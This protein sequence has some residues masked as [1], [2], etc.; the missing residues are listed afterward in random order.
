MSTTIFNVFNFYSQYKIEI[1]VVVYA[2][3][4]ERQLLSYLGNFPRLPYW[5]LT[6]DNIQ[7]FQSSTTCHGS[8]KGLT[9]A[10]NKLM[11]AK[12]LYVEPPILLGATKVIITTMD[13]DVRIPTVDKATMSSKWRGKFPK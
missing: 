7:L 13:L 2:S 10:F 12:M 8:E 3:M 4:Y 1:F 6:K 11:V 5:S 9:G